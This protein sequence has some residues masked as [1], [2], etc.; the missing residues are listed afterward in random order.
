M[1]K[2]WEYFL[3]ALSTVATVYASATIGTG[4][5]FS[6]QLKDQRNIY[7]ALFKGKEKI[8]ADVAP[9]TEPW[10]SFDLNDDNKL[11]LGELFKGAKEGRLEISIVEKPGK[12]PTIYF[13]VPG[14]SKV[15]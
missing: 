4:Y 8:V 9:L 13:H 12:R 11:S 2:N 10:D 5:S 7:S 1:V 3:V 14:S 15:K 6:E